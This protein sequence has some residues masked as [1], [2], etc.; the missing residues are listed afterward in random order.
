V[1]VIRQEE[2]SQLF[3]A[4][5]PWLAESVQEIDY[6]LSIKCSSSALRLY[7]AMSE[8]LLHAHQAPLQPTKAARDAMLFAIN[9]IV[10]RL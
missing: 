2:G 4:A 1:E 3:S 7:A 10:K 6:E 5:S 9:F 8:A